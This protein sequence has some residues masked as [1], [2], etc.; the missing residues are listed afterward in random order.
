[1]DG[2]GR[3]K[4]GGEE[5]TWEGWGDACGGKMGSKVAPPPHFVPSRCSITARSS[6]MLHDNGRACEASRR[7]FVFGLTCFL[8]RVLCSLLPRPPLPPALS[9][10]TQGRETKKRKGKQ[11]QSQMHSAV[12]T[13]TALASPR[14]MR[15]AKFR[16]F[17][18]LWE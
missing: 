4:C 9:S 17:F 16:M 18:V 15:K 6:F 10:T 11:R 14:N 8:R 12:E 2:W 1:M 7:G 5:G 3:E 13:F